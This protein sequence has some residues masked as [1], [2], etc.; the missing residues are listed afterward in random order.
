MES[1]YMDIIKKLENK[2]ILLDTQLKK[3][4][5]SEPSENNGNQ[6]NYDNQIINI[7][8]S[9]QIKNENE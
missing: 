3:K 2:N 4:L 5:I 9:G 8:I 6:L 7:E 1:K